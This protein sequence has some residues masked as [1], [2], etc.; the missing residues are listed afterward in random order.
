MNLNVPLPV[1]RV[2]APPKTDKIEEEDRR[3]E[4]RVD[5]ARKDPPKEPFDA[6]LGRVLPPG[7]AP[8]PTHA[9][10]AEGEPATIDSE[11]LLASTMVRP[12]WLLKALGELPAPAPDTPMLNQTVPMRVFNPVSQYDSHQVLEAV[13]EGAP[14]HVAHFPDVVMAQ[15]TQMQLRGEPV[16]RLAVQIAPEA[17]GK[18]SLAFTLQQQAVTVSIVAAHQQAKEQL[19]KQIH[20][21]EGI[22]RSHQLK[23]SEVKV[24]VAQPGQQQSGQFS[25]S[26]EGGYRAPNRWRV[27]RGGDLDQGI[28]VTVG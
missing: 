3:A 15:L 19:D 26:Q 25:D 18:V 4:K 8:E 11:S 28:D 5:D 13:K 14:I 17:L 1:D 21:I 22:L 24:E 23:P 2:V 6:H 16:T 12:G 7:W 9:P 27:R 10:V 20:A